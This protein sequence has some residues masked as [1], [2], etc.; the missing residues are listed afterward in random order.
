MKQVLILGAGRS[1][2]S[3]INYL[4]EQASKNDWKVVIGEQDTALAKKKFPDAEVIP[5][6]ILDTAVAESEIEKAV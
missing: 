1:S 3:L 6:D 2:T 5:F 4:L